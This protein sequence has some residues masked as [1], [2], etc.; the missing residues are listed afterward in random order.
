[1]LQQHLD[2]KSR[3]FQTSVYTG[4]S[5][6]GPETS[7]LE[8]VQIYVD[9]I[10]F[11]DCLCFPPND[12]K[13]GPDELGVSVNETLYQD[14]PKESHLVAVKRISR[15]LKDRKSTFGGCQIFGGKLVY[16]S[17]KKQTSVAMS[18]AELSIAITISN[19]PVL[20]SRT[21]HIDIRYHFIR[22]HIL[23]GDIKLR[24]VQADL[25]LADIFSKPLAE[26]SFT[27][28]IA[29]LGMLNIENRLD[30]S[31]ECVHVPPKET[32]KAG[33][34]TMDLPTW[35]DE[36]T[37]TSHMCKVADHS[38]K[39][40]QSLI[41]PFGEVNADNTA[42]K[43]LS[44]T[45]IPPPAKEF[46]VTVDATKSLYAS[47]SAEV[48]GN[49]PEIADSE[50]VLEQNVIEKEDAGVHSLEEPTFE[51]LMDE[52]DK[53][54]K[55]AQEEPESPYDKES[56]IKIVK[57]FK[58]YW[59]IHPE[60][61]QPDDANITFMG[62]GPID[63]ELDDPGSDLYYMPSNDLASLTGFETPNSNDEDSNS[64]TK[65]HST[66]NLNATLDGDVA[67]PNAYASV[68]ALFDPR[69]HLL[70]ELTTISSK[71]VQLESQ[72]TKQVSDELK[73]SVPSLVS[74]ALKETLPAIHEG[75]DFSISSSGSSELEELLDSRI[76]KAMNK[77]FHAF[78]K[79]ESR[80]FVLLQTELSKVIQSKIGSNVKARVRTGMR[81]VTERL[82][83][84]QCSIT[85]NSN[86]DSDLNE[87]I[88]TMNFL[89]EAT[90][91][92][93]RIETTNNVDVYGKKD[94]DSNANSSELSHSK[95][96]AKSLA[97][98]VVC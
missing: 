60:I 70:R 80:R 11:R 42:D 85:E 14:N 18:S 16:W 43:S 66:N 86:S 22:D 63:M 6:V 44:G 5:S 37:L 28:L 7:F 15:Y 1:M 10:I 58:T 21:K 81:H 27:R 40:I 96:S 53:Q 94:S 2:F 64:V 32:V 93:Q 91:V 24:F 38:P 19:N 74:A 59:S 88:K 4:Q 72:I 29:E 36:T 69:G 31:D 17:A 61:D 26:P 45:S 84:L 54:N 78:N 82:D 46:V 92:E 89:L 67:L 73:S 13:L 75:A 68:S 65:E 83:P 57:S 71:V 95:A 56:E 62:S 23:K 52:V 3:E 33:L 50:K 51:Q 77:Q 9:D 39:H 48:Q 98:E 76:Y 97:A 49:Q 12:R 30:R 25:Q 35:K 34:A 8:H 87:A 90:K 79:L 55:A 20:H 41:L 47:E